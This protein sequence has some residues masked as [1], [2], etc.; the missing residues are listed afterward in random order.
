[1]IVS[2]AVFMWISTFMI[3]GLG[4]AWLVV[5]VVRLRRALRDDL[6]DPAVRDRVFGSIVGLG[7]VVLALTGP[8]L[9]HLG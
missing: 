1:V 9:Y 2:H 8:L 5:D 3:A 7:C 4:A 6:R